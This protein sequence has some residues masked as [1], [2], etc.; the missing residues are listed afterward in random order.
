MSRTR[1]TTL[2]VCTIALAVALLALVGG[3]SSSSKTTS[4]GAAVST[5]STSAD[6]STTAAGGVPGTPTPPASTTPVTAQL[7]EGTWTTDAAG[8]V[9]ANAATNRSLIGLA[10]TGPV[11]L[12]F[13]ADG[14]FAHRGSFSCSQAGA[15]GTGQFT[16]SG[17]YVLTG[18]QL[19][20]SDVTS[21]G[22]VSIGDA[23]VAFDPSLRNGTAT[24]TITETILSV[25]APG[26]SGTAPVTI[27][28]TR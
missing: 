24:V 25:T 22:S 27:N 10:C 4:K 8:I 15:S 14:T 7:I 19:A 17:K 5:S 3:C 9:A 13:N 21:S 20:L 16:G 23:S 12:T 18:D 26:P 1:R 2:I 6:T 11:T 28:Y